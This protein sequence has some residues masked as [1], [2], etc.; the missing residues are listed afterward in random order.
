MEKIT[1]IIPSWNEGETLKRCVETIRENNPEVQLIV[2]NN[3]STDGTQDWLEQQQLD[4][5]YFDEGV[6]T[7]GKVFNTVLGNFAVEEKVIFM[8]PQVQVGR[9]TL[10]E[11]VDT[12]NLGEEVGIVGCCS[13]KKPYE[14][15]IEVISYEEMLELE[16]EGKRK[17]KRRRDCSV[18]GN[19]GFCFGMKRDV[20]EQLGRFDENLSYTDVMVDY[21]LRAIK[22]NYKNMISSNAYS[23]EVEGNEENAYWINCLRHAERDILRKK[24]NMNYFM[25]SANYKFNFLIHR[26]EE[27]SFSVLEVGCDMGANLLG[28]KNQYPKCR[29]YGL[30]INETAAELGSHIADIRY[31]NIEDEC[32]DFGEKFDYIIFG[33][34]L[35]HLHNPQQTVKYCKELLKEN[36]RIIASIPNVMHISVMNQ[37]LRGEFRYTDIGLLDKTHIHLF[38]Q[39]EIVRMFAE[40]NYEI[41]EM[42]GVIYELEEEEEKLLG[43]LMQISGEHVTEQ[44]YKTYQYSVVARKCS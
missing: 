14:Q 43:K 44:M 29:I 27:E 2:A 42:Q 9:Y 8:W 10:Q 1:V 4:S 36:G 5:I 23:F 28:I 35:E 12:M 15:N 20:L 32:V 22:E 19:V 26:M 37:L 38:T 21:Q 41:E 34:V 40:E 3:G 18:L 39:K 24:W 6:Q 33:D 17:A 31:G 11:M 13:N 16:K 25:L 7:I 30:E